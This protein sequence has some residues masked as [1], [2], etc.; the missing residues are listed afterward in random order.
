MNSL[1][2]LDKPKLRG[3]SH[4]YAALIAIPMAAALIIKADYS[5]SACVYGICLILLFTVSATYHR[6]RWS[7]KNRLFMRRLDHAMIFIFIAGCY[8]PFGL[9][10]LN[11]TKIGQLMM[12]AIWL[13]A[14]LGAIFTI[15]WPK[16]PKWVRA[17]L[18]VLTGWMLT[19]TFPAT[20]EVLG[21]L[22]VSLILGSGLLYTLGAIIYARKAPNP[23]P[24]Y[25][26]YHEIFHA[27][28]I[29]A[30]WIHYS[31]IYGILY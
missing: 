24:G 16:T 22:S 21:G 14:G 25:F 2:D 8:T 6:V 29:V 30:S 4:Q 11:E 31:V 12:I 1:P 26:G 5:F 28:V 19:L 7:E 23:I 18:Y 3:F 27:L 20:Y 17:S 10:V 13:A 9:E 15:Y